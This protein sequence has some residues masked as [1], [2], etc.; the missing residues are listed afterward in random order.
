MICN[1]RFR[2]RNIPLNVTLDNE[3]ITEVEYYKYLGLNLDRH[4]NF[5]YHARKIA[6]KVSACTSAL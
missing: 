2:A 4:L 5:E 3:E 1:S 6:G